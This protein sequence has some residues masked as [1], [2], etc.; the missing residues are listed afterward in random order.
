MWFLLYFYSHLCLRCHAI[1]L[2]DSYALSC[3][4]KQ[5]FSHSLLY[6]QMFCLRL[7]RLCTSLV[8]Q[9]IAYSLMEKSKHRTNWQ[10]NSNQ[11][12]NRSPET[13][14]LS[15]GSKIIFLENERFIT[16]KFLYKISK[17][18]CT[19]V[20]FLPSSTSALSCDSF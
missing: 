8:W 18:Q 4:I 12:A 19:T 20:S 2:C 11:F 15:R 1:S 13:T 14:F 5:T 7:H 3:E 9:N 6:L 17:F 10:Y 16:V